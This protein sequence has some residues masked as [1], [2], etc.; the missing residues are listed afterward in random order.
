MAAQLQGACPDVI[1]YAVQIGDITCGFDTL[2]DDVAAAI[3][4]VAA[5]VVAEARA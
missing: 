1:V 3:P 2:T 5:M 4:D